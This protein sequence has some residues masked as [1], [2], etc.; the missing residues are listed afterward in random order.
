M[1]NKGLLLGGGK[2]RNPFTTNVVTVAVGSSYAYPEVFGFSNGTDALF[3]GNFGSIDSTDFYSS[4]IT[5]PNGERLELVAIANSS[6]EDDSDYIIISLWPRPYFFEGETDVYA[7]VYLVRLDKGIGAST[8]I[9][10]GAVGTINTDFVGG[11]FGASDVGKEVE[12][13]LSSN[14]PPFSWENVNTGSI[15]SPAS[16]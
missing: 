14:P 10:I 4:S 2:A 15:V 6:A 12:I 16:A 1:L 8:N 13:Y 7:D 11:L 5:G 3:R 9:F